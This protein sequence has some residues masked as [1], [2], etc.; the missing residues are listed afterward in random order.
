MDSGEKFHFENKYCLLSDLFPNA[1]YGRE[2]ID[3]TV[4]VFSELLDQVLFRCLAANVGLDG[5][6]SALYIKRNQI[7]SMFDRIMETWKQKEESYALILHC[8]QCEEDSIE[9]K[10][11]D[12]IINDKMQS[13]NVCDGAL[14]EGVLKDLLALVPGYGNGKGTEK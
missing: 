10:F 7:K 13:Y 3:N 9:R 5:V 1:D 14:S 12:E 8:C 11:L 2:N 4:A 6:K